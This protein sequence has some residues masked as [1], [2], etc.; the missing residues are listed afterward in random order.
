MAQET[1][2]KAKKT[3]LLLLLLLLRTEACALLCGSLTDRPPTSQERHNGPEQPFHLEL[4]QPHRHA[5]EAKL[6]PLTLSSMP[7]LPAV[8]L[9]ARSRPRR[10]RRSGRRRVSLPVQHHVLPRAGVAEDQHPP[11]APL[12][13]SR[14]TLEKL[15]DGVDVLRADARGRPDLTERHV[16]WG[17]ALSLIHI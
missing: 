12:P 10:K 2:T 4:Q 14:G 16:R 13:I 17:E 9:T 5:A 3:L 1:I 11:A 15:H 7:H 6:T 8:A